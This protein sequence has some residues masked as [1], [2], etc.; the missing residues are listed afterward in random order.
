MRIAR[1][2][3]LLLLR[4]AAGGPRLVL[5]V[6]PHKTGSSSVQ[7]FLDTAGEWLDA[8]LGVRYSG[9]GSKNGKVFGAQFANTLMS[10]LG[11]D[12]DDGGCASLKNALFVV[13]DE[14]FENMT[15]AI[16][17][18]LAAPRNATLVLSAE[19]LDRLPA[20]GWRWLSDWARRDGFALAAA[21][22]HRDESSRLRAEWGEHAKQ[23]ALAQG[24][25]GAKTGRSPPSLGAFALT[26]PDCFQS[27]AALLARLEAALGRENV[28]AASYDRLLERNATAPAFVVCNATLELGGAPFRACARAVDARAR[29]LPRIN[30]SPLPAAIDVVRLARAA[31]GVRDSLDA[32]AGARC[33]R[34]RA[35]LSPFEP[36]VVLV[37]QALPQTCGHFGSLFDAEQALW[38]RRTGAPR[39]ESALAGHDFCL[40]DEARLEAEHWTRIRALLP[41]EVPKG[42]SR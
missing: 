23:T 36:A 8:E 19:A 21:V 16:A 2:W 33:E 25:S 29:E 20:R 13:G 37:A 32:A 11:K 6:G 22:L 40:V 1:G 30:S 10:R 12:A 31:E 24:G 28:F 5:H 9:F 38:F 3:L 4:A 26:D 27:D 7:K 14:A 34:R 18:E 41:Q 42:C 15:R 39:P 35:K 17:A